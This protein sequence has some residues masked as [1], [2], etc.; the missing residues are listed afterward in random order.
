MYKNK[1]IVSCT[2]PYSNFE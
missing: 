2:Q 1:V